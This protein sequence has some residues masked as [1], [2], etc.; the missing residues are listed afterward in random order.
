MQGGDADTGSASRSSLSR[1]RPAAAGRNGK[2]KRCAW[3]A[4]VHLPEGAGGVLR[5]Y[6]SRDGLF[7]RFSRLLQAKGR[8]GGGSRCWET[9]LLTFSAGGEPGRGGVFFLG[10]SGLGVRE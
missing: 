1:L 8:G 5:A 9:G 4:G 2:G 7:R 6:Q 3:R 10:F